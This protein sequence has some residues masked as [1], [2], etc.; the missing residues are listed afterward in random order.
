MHGLGIPQSIQS[1]DKEGSQRPVPALGPCP[2]QR[3]ED[4]EDPQD[5]F[6]QGLLSICCCP[7]DA[8]SGF[9]GRCLN[10]CL[11]YISLPKKCVRATTHPTDV[12]LKPGIAH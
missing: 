1:R 4:S 3:Q 7:K 10:S 9:P 5:A 6:R 8:Q 2:E 12:G 11:L